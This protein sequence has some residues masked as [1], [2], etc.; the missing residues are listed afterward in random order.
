[1]G[2]LHF[3]LLIANN[4][5]VLFPKWSFYS[6]SL[7]F[8]ETLFDDLLSMCY[9]REHVFLIWSVNFY[10]SISNGLNVFINCPS[11]LMISKKILE[12]MILSLLV[13]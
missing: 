4:C 2:V 8:V 10:M 9:C 3:S 5:I 12:R 11:S 13:Y 7:E 6:I 1:M